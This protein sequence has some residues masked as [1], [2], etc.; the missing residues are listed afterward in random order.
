MKKLYCH[1]SLRNEVLEGASYDIVGETLDSYEIIDEK[2]YEHAFSKE[3]DEFGESYKTWFNL[4]VVQ[5]P[6]LKPLEGFL[7]DLGEIGG[8]MKVETTRKPPT[9]SD[10]A[11]TF[12]LSDEQTEKAKQWMKER[13][14]HVGAIGGQFT[15]SFTPTSLG[16]IVTVSDGKE[17]LSLTNKDLW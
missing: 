17:E 7:V 11:Y 16:N 3:P 8:V 6:K 15:F 9:Y 13:E 1:T 4:V 12:K 2:G 10:K 14:K 5:K